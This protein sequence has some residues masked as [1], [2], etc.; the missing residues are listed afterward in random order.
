MI[1]FQGDEIKLLSKKPFRKIISV[2]PSQTE[3]LFDLGLNDEVIGI[4]K[5]CVHPKEWFKNK[6]RIGGT[7][8]L[9]IEKIKSLSPDFVIANEE[10]NLKSEIEIIAEFSDVY[11]SRIKNLNDALQMIET[12]AT[13]VAKT[14]EGI[15]ISN[16]IQIAFEGLNKKTDQQKLNAAYLIWNDPIMTIGADTF[17]SNMMKHAGF[18][19]VFDDQ[20]RYPEINIE[21]LRQINPDVL[22]LSSEPF[23]FSEKHVQ[24]F[25][26]HVPKTKVILV[27]GEMFSWFGSRLIKAPDYFETIKH[28]WQ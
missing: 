15:S 20:F 7:K 10:E 6:T 26:N 14:N 8:K 18:K 19:N 16:Q 9:N 27:D 23:P 2:V 13:L 1:Y 28:Q 5:F 3:L 12:V 4:T 25:Q 17:I 11:V 21:Q 24:H 22:L